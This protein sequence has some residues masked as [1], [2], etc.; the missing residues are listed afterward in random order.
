MRLRLL[1]VQV[2]LL[3][4]DLN[5]CKDKRQ[6]KQ[7]LKEMKLVIDQINELILTESSALESEPDSAPHRALA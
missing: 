2:D 7:L 3:T 6:R 4:S 1:A 5:N